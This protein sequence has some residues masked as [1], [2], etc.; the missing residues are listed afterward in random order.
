MSISHPFRTHSRFQN[1]ISSALDSRMKQEPPDLTGA[2]A[3]VPASI[4]QPSGQ[5]GLVPFEPVPVRHR[6]DGWT[7][8][9]QREFLEALADTGVVL[10]AAARA[11]MTE[12]SVTR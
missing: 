4:P 3:D 9:K 11:C 6:R 2:G 8:Q 7:P 12:Q 1:R 5:T 10:V